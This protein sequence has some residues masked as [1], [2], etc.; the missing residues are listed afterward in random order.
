MI[1]TLHTSVAMFNIALAELIILL[2]FFFGLVFFIG[3]STTA[4]PCTAGA[5]RSC[6]IKEGNG[7]NSGIKTQP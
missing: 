7:T 1:Y 5:D 2:I 3:F 4:H 6:S